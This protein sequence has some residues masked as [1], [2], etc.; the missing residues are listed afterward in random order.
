M[1]KITLPVLA[2]V[3]LTIP[4]L[5]DAQQRGRGDRGGR[6]GFMRQQ[7][8]IQAFLQA[9]DLGLNLTDDQTSQLNVLRAQ[10]DETN[11]PAREALAALVEQASGGFDQ[12]LREQMQ[13]HRQAMQ[14][15]NEAALQAVRAEVLT[16]EQWT[17]V[18]T[19][20]ETI[21]PQRRGGGRRGGRGGR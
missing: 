1:N 9:D 12:S 16:D 13:P 19:Y 15:S 3:L 21:Q 7:N 14:E 11:A 4:Q 8:P 18:R 10:L 17:A 2:L 5:L 20:L 6:G